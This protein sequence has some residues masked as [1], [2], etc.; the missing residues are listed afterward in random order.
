MNIILSRILSFNSIELSCFYNEIFHNNPENAKKYF[1]YL[2]SIPDSDLDEFYSKL[3]NQNLIQWYKSQIELC[4]LN[5]A[6]NEEDIIAI[7]NNIPEKVQIIEKN[8]ELAKIKSTEFREVLKANFKSLSAVVSDQSKGVDFP[9]VQKEFSGEMIGLPDFNESIIKKQS[10]FDCIKDRKSNRSFKN[11]S[12]SLQELSFL[13]WATQGVKEKLQNGKVTLRTVPSG[14][15]RH[16]FETYLAVNNVENLSSGVYRYQPLEHSLVF[17]FNLENQTADL[18]VAALGQSFVGE[19]AVTFIWSAIPYR[20]EWRY[21]TESKKIILQDSG[22]LCQN[23]YVACEALGLG[24]CAIGAYNQ[25][26]FDDLLKLDG[27][28]EFTVYVAP[29]GKI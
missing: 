13:L 19:S 20:T 15:A 21:T 8:T 26:L 23:L 25:E 6:G 14:G 24:T 16:P 28:D 29:V 18:T 7:I 4:N 27:K 2:K 3:I 22:H 11:E 5:E 1:A 9:S 12:I 17:L 10:V